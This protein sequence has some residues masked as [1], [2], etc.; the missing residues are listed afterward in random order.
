MEPIGFRVEKSRE[1]K[2]PDQCKTKGGHATGGSQGLGSAA[3]IMAKNGPLSC[4]MPIQ[5]QGL[6]AQDCGP[7]AF[8]Q[9]YFI[10]AGSPEFR[11]SRTVRYRD[12]SRRWVSCSAW[13][14]TIPLRF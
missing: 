2:L 4:A 1:F 5:T 8:R 7:H 13:L 14:R 12:L 10:E 9:A 3:N 11:T 6:A